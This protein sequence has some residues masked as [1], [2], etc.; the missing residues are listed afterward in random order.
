MIPPVDAN[1]KSLAI[2]LSNKCNLS[3]GYCYVAAGRSAEAFLTLSQIVSV[4]DHFMSS[5]ADFQKK[6]LFLGG[7]PMTNYALLRQA[8]SYTRRSYGQ[9]LSVHVFTNGLGLNSES[10]NFFAENR[11]ELLISP[12]GRDVR[13]PR[14]IKG[15][16]TGA[17]IIVRP[18]SVSSLPR[19]AHNLFISGWRKII[20]SIDT[21]SLWQESEAFQLERALKGLLHY[22]K[23]LIHLRIHPFE[24]S[25]L[26]DIS[27]HSICSQM[28]LG[29]DGFF[30][31]CDKLLGTEAPYLKRWRIGSADRGPD[32]RT[33]ERHQNLAARAIIKALPDFAYGLG[34]GCP[35]GV[36]WLWQAQS[37]EYNDFLERAKNFRLVSAIFSDFLSH[38]RIQM[39]GNRKLERDS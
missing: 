15:I 7:E 23:S 5:P 39:F 2:Y 30:Y 27:A 35:L 16:Q 3:C 8:I 17:V 9:K 13:L 29:S 38:L 31:P 28:I 25:N 33:L 37:R 20:I 19:Q 14:D 12:H 4:I 1:P 10:L 36:Y 21:V 18:K 11:V 32:R 22:Y 24:I 34:G 26:S 6:V